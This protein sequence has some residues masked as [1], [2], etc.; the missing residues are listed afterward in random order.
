M[1]GGGFRVDCGGFRGDVV[2]FRVERCLFRRR[3][4]WFRVW[5]SDG[6]G[7]A[8]GCGSVVGGGFECGLV[9]SGWWWWFRVWIGG[10]VVVS[11]VDRWWGD[12]FG[13]MVVVSGG[14]VVVSGGG[15]VVSGGGVVIS[16]GGVLGWWFRWQSGCGQSNL[17][18]ELGSKERAMQEHN[19]I[20]SKKIKERG[21]N[22]EHVQQ[23]QWQNQHQQQP[24]P[25]PQNHQVPPDASNFM[26]PPPIPS[27]NTG[28]YQG[29]F[30]G[31][32]RR[33]DLDLTLEPIYSCHMGCFTT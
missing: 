10:E 25:P 12:G 9:V 30:G 20:L 17:L 2:V 22:L 11:G 13:L 31:E 33:N 28:G 27:L 6:G 3:I 32:V 18:Q 1:E 8:F 21:K 4:W 14:G 24:P 16:C 19:N 5:I 23:M 26:L 29:Q 7:G 15:V